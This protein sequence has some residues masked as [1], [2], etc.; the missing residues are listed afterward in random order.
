M[1]SEALLAISAVIIGAISLF[2]LLTAVRHRLPTLLP[3]DRSQL[4]RVMN[5]QATFADPAADTTGN[6][7]HL[8]QSITT[9]PS[10]KRHSAK[11][12]LAK[13]LRYARWQIS[14]TTW[15]FASL[16]L[17]GILLSIAASQFNVAIQ[18]LS[19]LAGPC[20]MN[21]ALEIS[22]DRRSAAFDADYSQFLMSMVGLLRTGMT[23][24]GALETA[25]R[26]L[27][28]ASLVRQEVLL[29]LE[30]IRVG[31]PE[32]SSIGAFG[33]DIYHPELEL[34][35]QALLLSNRI[36]GNLSDSLERLSKQVRKRQYFKTSAISAV[37]LQRGSLA[38]IIVILFLLQSY[39]ALVSPK[40]IVDSLKTEAGR[41][42]WQ[43]SAATIVLSI[44][45]IRRITR[46]RV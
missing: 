8:V 17:S 15:I 14:P 21:M 33:D 30:R 9:A 3:S 31:V 7:A 20:I 12:T 38:I 2:T 44:A 40:L 35:V 25:A 24:T 18:V 11:L 29:L 4:H 1:S 37:A 45:W 16:C 26:G 6:H 39:M 10:A 36:G 13:R 43:V 5:S 41:H 22:M 23:A 46:L 28:P 42:I 32:D 34:F 19:V 27:K